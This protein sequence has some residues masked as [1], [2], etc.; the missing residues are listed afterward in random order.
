MVSSEEE[1]IARIKAA[2]KFLFFSS[3][4]FKARVE[5]F[6]FL[7]LHGGDFTMSATLVWVYAM[8]HDA[9]PFDLA[10]AKKEGRLMGN[11]TL[12]LLKVKFLLS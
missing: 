9:F 7:P 10:E 4:M 11:S 6:V 5:N 8:L 2:F 12:L 1:T 3:L